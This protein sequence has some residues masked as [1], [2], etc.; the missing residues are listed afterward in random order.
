MTLL[1]FEG[2]SDSSV[3]SNNFLPMSFWF[4]FF[5]RLKTFAIRRVVL[6]CLPY[7]TISVC[8][9]LRFPIVTTSLIDYIWHSHDV[10][11]EEAPPPQ[12]GSRLLQMVVGA[13]DE[14]TKWGGYSLNNVYH[15]FRMFKLL[16]FS[17]TTWW[18]DS[19]STDRVGWPVWPFQP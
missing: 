8:P 13:R 6:R 16:L 11:C 14:A 4:Q 7:G 17:E 5:P 12:W 1:H 2:I 10:R 18:N 3:P 19:S 9:I 15:S